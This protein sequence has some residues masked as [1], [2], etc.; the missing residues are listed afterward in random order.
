MENKLKVAQEFVNN[1]IPNQELSYANQLTV[2]QW[3]DIINVLRV[4]TNTTTNYLRQL[5]SWLIG[6]NN[7]EDYAVVEDG[8]NLYT[9]IKTELQNF[10][11]YIETIKK[12]FITI[13]DEVQTITGKKTFKHF[14]SDKILPETKDGMIGD[15]SNQFSTAH[16][17]EVIT[18]SIVPIMDNTE[19]GVSGNIGKESL[20]WNEAFIKGIHADTL[21]VKTITLDGDDL[22]TWTKLHV[23][24]KINALWKELYE[25]DSDGVIDSIKEITKALEEGG[26]YY[27]VFINKIEE[28]ALKSDFEKHVE[29]MNQ[30][31]EDHL[32]EFENHL[33]ASNDRIEEVNTNIEMHRQNKEWIVDAEGNGS[34]VHE[35]NPHDVDK[36]QMPLFDT[37]ADTIDNTLV[38]HAGDINANTRHRNTL[39]NP[40]H[41]GIDDIVGLKEALQEGTKGNKLI[42]AHIKNEVDDNG[43]ILTDGSKNNNPHKV[44]HEQVIGLADRLNELEE[45]IKAYV[46]DGTLVVRIKKGDSTAT[47]NFTANQDTQ[48]GIEFGVPVK[49]EELEDAADY[50]KKTDIG[51]GVHTITVNGKH[52]DNN[53]FRANSPDNVTTDIPVP[54]KLSDLKDDVIGKGNLTIQRND[55]ELAKFNA[56]SKEDVSVNIQ[57]PTTVEELEDASEYPRLVNG[58]IP[59]KYLPSFVDDV[60]EFDSKDLFPKTGEVGKIYVDTTSNLTYRWTG[61]QYIHVGGADLTEIEARVGTLEDKLEDLEDKHDKDIADLQEGLKNVDIGKGNLII[62]QDGLEITRFNANSKEDVTLALEIPEPNLSNYIQKGDN[63]SL[64]TNDAGYISTIPSEYITETELAAELQPYTLQDNIHTED[65]AALKKAINDIIGGDNPEELPEDVP[66]LNN[67][68]G[69]GILTIKQDGSTLGA[70]SANSKENVEINI[71]T[72]SLDL[73]SNLVYIGDNVSLLNNNV[74][75]LKPNDNVSS[76]NNDAGYITIDDIPESDLS[77]Y[78]QKGDNVSLLNNNVGYLKPKDNVS[79]LTNDAGYISTIPS[80]YITETELEKETSSGIINTAIN[81]KVSA[82]RKELYEVDNDAVLDSIM[83]IS[84]ALKNNPNIITLLEDSIA[85]K[86]DKRTSATTNSIV[87]FTSDGNSKTSGVTIDDSNYITATGYK[88]PNKTSNDILLADGST[89]SKD[90]FAGADLDSKYVTLASAQTISG[91]K[92]FTGNVVTY[93]NKFEIKATSVNDDSWIIL[94]NATDASYYAFGIR[95]PYASYGLQM[96]YHPAS[97]SD[98]YYNIWHS[99]NDGAG[100]NLDADL[101]DGKQGAYYLD[102]NNFTN[103]PKSTINIVAGKGL[104]AGGSFTL[105]QTTPTDIVINIASSTL[106]VTDDSIDLATSGVTAGTYGT[107]QTPSHSGTFVIPKITVDKYGR[108]TAV[109]TAS[110]TLPADKDTDSDKKTSSNS[111][112]NK[113]YLV[114]A[115]TKSAN[116]VTTNTND[117]VYAMGNGVLGAKQVRVDSSTTGSTKACIMQYD[118]SINALKFVFA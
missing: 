70:F 85:T 58:L 46:K 32:E 109:S 7:T 108:I 84:N 62:T 14:I 112:T 65:I 111:T 11:N 8:L 98:E 22:K 31:F 105:N 5:H 28:R 78:I 82:L 40:H 110:I 94:S 71:E 3:N 72:P 102:Y 64:L 113:I 4:Q 13:G 44:T 36:G 89:I 33:E 25:I 100:S 66:N 47:Y 63:V 43:N 48:T 50:A 80:E 59:N 118:E 101:L 35:D 45:N 91:N 39:G 99:G 51:D 68:I 54:E 93:N 30:L 90:S 38:T 103:T 17:K 104:T 74:G 26:E 10:E 37:W 77:N 42:E 41:T 96:K 95:R 52:I 86:M 23:Q 75:Y 107:N 61:T 21:N 55:E 67:D 115:E 2:K 18:D 20:Y 56:D 79:L 15:G 60:L 27:Q 87:R 106:S 83:E 81:N 1:S 114:G 117:S 34:W 57:V 19:S 69:E 116:G 76:L 97:G 53:A 16:I 9:W 49:V 92:T 6:I 88:I 12:S 29:D 73:P 24:E